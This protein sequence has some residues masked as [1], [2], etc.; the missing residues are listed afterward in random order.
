VESITVLLVR[1]LKKVEIQG[2]K[3]LMI[4]RSRKREER[5]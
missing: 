1:T 3:A 5:R 2:N 4:G